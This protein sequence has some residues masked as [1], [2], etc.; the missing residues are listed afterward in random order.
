VKYQCPADIG[1]DLQKEIMNTAETVYRALE[2]RDFARIDF[3]LSPEERLYFIEINP[4]PGLA[5]G[6]SDFPMIAEFCG[7][8]YATLIQNILKCALNRYGLHQRAGRMQ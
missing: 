5:P 2:C 7:M 8:G 1:A 4:L 6:Y 3:R